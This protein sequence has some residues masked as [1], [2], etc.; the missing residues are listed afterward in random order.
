MESVGRT[1]IRQTVRK[2]PVKPDHTFTP[3]LERLRFQSVDETPKSLQMIQYL[4]KHPKASFQ[5]KHQ[6]YLKAQGEIPEH[7]RPGPLKKDSH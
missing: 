5:E 3:H 2:V 7:L 6:V 1:L 4:L